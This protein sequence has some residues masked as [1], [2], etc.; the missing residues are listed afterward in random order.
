MA[1]ATEELHFSFH[2]IS[3][4]ISIATCI[5]PGTIILDSI[6]LKTWLKG[7]DLAPLKFKGLSQA[8]RWKMDWILGGVEAGGQLRDG[9]AAPRESARLRLD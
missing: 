2:F 5:C 6:D 9:R 1:S 4:S 3:I 8:A 7:S